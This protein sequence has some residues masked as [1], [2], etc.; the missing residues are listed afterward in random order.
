MKPWDRLQV[1]IGAFAEEG[2]VPHLEELRRL[3]LAAV[4]D[5]APTEEHRIRGQLARAGTAQQL[6]LVHSDIY[7]A[8]ARRHCEFEA[9]R[10]IN[11]LSDAF[12]GHLPARTLTR[13]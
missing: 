12:E 11:A 2:K 4:A 7:Q 1:T 5:C 9:A 13:R 6:W 8:V 3:S 10:R